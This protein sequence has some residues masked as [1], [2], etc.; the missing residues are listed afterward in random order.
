[1]DSLLK[2]V[3]VSTWNKPVDSLMVAEHYDAEQQETGR[4]S[5]QRMEKQRLRRRRSMWSSIT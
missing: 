2:E 1:M 5:H 3:I 4:R